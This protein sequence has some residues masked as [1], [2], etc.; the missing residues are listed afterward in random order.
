MLMRWL[1][2]FFG[3]LIEILISYHHRTNMKHHNEFHSLITPLAWGGG[4][5]IVLSRDV[6]GSDRIGSS[7][8]S[9]RI[10]LVLELNESILNS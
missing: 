3:D 8:F 1:C 4:G 9:D 5:G 6:Q 7:D 2:Y 10:G